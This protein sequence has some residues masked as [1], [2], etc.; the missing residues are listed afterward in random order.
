MRIQ[1]LSTSHTSI[2]KLQPSQKSVLPVQKQLSTPDRVS[3]GG[4]NDL[5]K[6]AISTEFNIKSYKEVTNMFENLWKCALEEGRLK[7]SVAS[8]I[9]TDESSSLISRLK[10]FRQ[11]CKSNLIEHDEI[12]V[13]RNGRPLVTTYDKSVNFRDPFNPVYRDKDIKFGFSKDKLVVERLYD[14]TKFYCDHT[15]GI[16]S[17]TRYTTDFREAET[18]YYK[19]NGEE[20][21][22]KNFFEFFVS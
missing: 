6:K 21:S 18:T 19:R 9:L 11:G 1:A 13:E 3:F 2:V 14:K 8:T 17:F 10:R 22:L 15:R 16:S 20:N 12:I 5:F 4:Y 7:N